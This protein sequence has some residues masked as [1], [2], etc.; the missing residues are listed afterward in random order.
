MKKTYAALVLLALFAFAIPL[1]AAD[2]VLLGGA[3]SD[4]GIAA[5]PAGLAGAY[6]AIAD[7]GNAAWWN[8]A[9][10]GLMDKK[11][12]VCFSYIPN[13]YNL[14]TGDI[15]RML[16]T[17]GQ[18]DTGGYGGLGASISYMNV[19][20]GSD[21]TGDTT[22]KWSEYVLSVSWGME[23]EQ[24]LGLVKYKFPK[25]AVGVNAK[26]MGVS[27]DLTLGTAKT[28]AT[29]F[30]ADLGL[31]F[32]IKNNFNIG[33]MAKNIYSQVSWQGGSS[34]RLP[35]SLNAGV[36]YGITPDFLVTA[37]LKTEESDSGG[38]SGFGMPAIT[39]YCGAAEYIIRFAKG[40]SVESVALRSGITIDPSNDV[41]TIPAGASLG[42]ENFSVDFVYQ[43]YL[44]SL[45]ASDMYRL[46]ITAFF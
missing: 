24:F 37:E 33:V 22:Y 6:T 11:K 10:V 28:G 16:L 35:Y 38:A 5:R 19:N 31:I 42:M 4:D 41:Y 20:M 23:V 44:K 26:Y 1:Y 12:S 43:F 29:G 45:L 32:A 14:T 36:F 2:N 7:D 18:G 34:E 27:T 30:G 13:I 9:G 3:F 25:I 8:P 21:Y 17:Y 39:A 40:S 46:G 15:T